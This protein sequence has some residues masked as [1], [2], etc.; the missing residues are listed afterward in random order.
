MC[1]LW[2]VAEASQNK[3][4]NASSQRKEGGEKSMELLEDDD[5]GTREEPPINALQGL[6]KQDD[7][8]NPNQQTSHHLIESSARFSCNLAFVLLVL[9]F[10]SLPLPRD[11]QFCHLHVL[12]PCLLL[13][14]PFSP[15]HT[16]CQR[17]PLHAILLLHLT[18]LQ[19]SSLPTL[20]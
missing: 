8:R 15:H 19:T 1:D 5:L 6:T 4:R 18:T 17:A 14:M 10:P 12:L 11:R 7:K 20:E 3:R 2:P 9:C 16:T 13:G